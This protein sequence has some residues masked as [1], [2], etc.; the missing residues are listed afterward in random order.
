[1][2]GFILAFAGYW[3]ISWVV[4]GVDGYILADGEW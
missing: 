2:Y 1:M 3:S 4:V